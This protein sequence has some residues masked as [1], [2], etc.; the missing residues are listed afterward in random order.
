[1]LSRIGAAIDDQQAIASI[2]ASMP[3]S[4]DAAHQLLEAILEDEYDRL[5]YR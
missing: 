1:M 3:C 5:P 2:A 4:A